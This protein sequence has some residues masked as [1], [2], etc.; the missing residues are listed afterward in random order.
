MNFLINRDLYIDHTHPDHKS[1]SSTFTMP[2]F[3]KWETDPQIVEVQ[4]TEFWRYFTMFPFN[5]STVVCTENV[6]NGVWSKIKAFYVADDQSWI[7]VAYPYST[8]GSSKD[9]KWK[10]DKPRYFKYQKCK[11]EFTSRSVGRCITEYTCRKCGFKNV[12]DSSD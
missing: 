3:G 4:D 1:M 10:L 11:H 6:D 8:F 7:I 9:S 2:A 5:V 12:V